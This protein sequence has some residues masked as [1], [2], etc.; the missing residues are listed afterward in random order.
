MVAATAFREVLEGGCHL[1]QFG[2]LALQ[3][4]NVIQGDP[5]HVGALAAAV[6]PELKQFLDFGRS[7]S[8]MPENTSTAVSAPIRASVVLRH[9]RPR[10]LA[11]VR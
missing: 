11:E 8:V 4:G 7:A 3:P 2:D 1:V 5:L 6:A 9:V 10:S